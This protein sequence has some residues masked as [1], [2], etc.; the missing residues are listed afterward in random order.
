MRCSSPSNSTY[1]SMASTQAP[2][3]QWL[4][5]NSEG[6]ISSPGQGVSSGLF[7]PSYF[8][9]PS[10]MQPIQLSFQSGSDISENK[11]IR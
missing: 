10:C 8:Q 6:M 9:S 1:L 4:N 3:N 7:G 11:Q 2:I 5:N